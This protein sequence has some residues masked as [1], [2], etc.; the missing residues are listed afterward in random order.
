MTK[1]TFIAQSGRILLYEY[2]GHTYMVDTR[3]KPI[4]D[5]HRLKRD[6]INRKIQMEEQK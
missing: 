3:H 5:Q 2:K 6:E 4:A 1:S